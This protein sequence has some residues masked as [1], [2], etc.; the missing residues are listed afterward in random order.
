MPIYYSKDENMC[1][2][3]LKPISMGMRE[4]IQNYGLDCD[5]ARWNANLG[6][7]SKP[8]SASVV[9][10]YIKANYDGED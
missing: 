10:Y 6:R 1:K 9:N 5:D 4:E 8:D 2:N 7:L 3:Y